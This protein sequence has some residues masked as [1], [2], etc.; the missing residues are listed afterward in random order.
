M[1]ALQ[2]CSKPYYRECHICWWK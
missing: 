1:P 2:C